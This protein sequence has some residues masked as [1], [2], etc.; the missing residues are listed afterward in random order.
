MKNSVLFLSDSPQILC[1][2]NQGKYSMAC[3]YC[4][5]MYSRQVKTWLT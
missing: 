1:R 5:S 3:G 4:R 2:N